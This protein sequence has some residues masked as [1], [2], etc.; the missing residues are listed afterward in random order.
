METE[1]IERKNRM[2][3]Q[4][5]YHCCWCGAGIYPSETNEG[6][7]EITVRQD[8]RRHEPRRFHVEKCFPRVEGAARGAGLTLPYFL[9]HLRCSICD[10]KEQ[11]HE[12]D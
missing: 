7:V 5:A 11:E 4:E 1:S 9:H 6:W 8:E 2:E 3:K 10:C 12:K